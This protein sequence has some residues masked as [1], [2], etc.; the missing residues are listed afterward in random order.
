MTVVSEVNDLATAVAEEIN[1][2]R[3]EIPLPITQTAYDA[4]SEPRPLRLYA[5]IPE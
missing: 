5:I 3:D 4:L 1:A 2:V